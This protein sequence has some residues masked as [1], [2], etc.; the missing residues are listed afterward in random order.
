[1]GERTQRDVDGGRGGGEGRRERGTGRNV[2]GSSRGREWWR[3]FDGRVVGVLV[4]VL[5]SALR[6]VLVLVLLL[7]VV[8]GVTAAGVGTG[9]WCWYCFA[10]VGF[11]VLGSALM[12]VLAFFFFL[13]SGGLVK[14]NRTPV[15]FG[16]QGTQ[17]PSNLSPIVPRTRLQS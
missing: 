7:T 8:G 6:S 12:L 14:M 5:M 16:G 10:V 13:S 2:W 3:Y 15:R 4:L 9:C 17:I 11:R 1:M